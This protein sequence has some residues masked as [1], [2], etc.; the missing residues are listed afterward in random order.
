MFI[1]MAK[2]RRTGRTLDD[3]VNGSGTQ[4]GKTVCDGGSSSAQENVALGEDA[5]GNVVSASKNSKAVKKVC[6]CKVEVTD[7]GSQKV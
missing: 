2:R 6:P 1:S 3:C 4:R 5:R 7:Y